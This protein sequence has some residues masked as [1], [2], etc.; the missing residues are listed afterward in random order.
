M[1]V[2]MRES[3]RERERN[4]EREERRARERQ[5]A[6]DLLNG[7]GVAEGVLLGRSLREEERL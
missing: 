4:G 7:A 2:R 5:R 3:E 6:R 1:S